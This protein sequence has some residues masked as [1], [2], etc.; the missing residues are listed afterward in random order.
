MPSSAPGILES[1]D[2]ASLRGEIEL[3]EELGPRLTGT[4][5]HER[6]ISHVADQLG[7]ARLE[8]REDVHSFTRWELARHPGSLELQVEGQLLEV[9]SAFPYSGTTGAAGV[10]GPLRL[11]HGPLP[12]WRAARGAIAVVAIR[13]RHLPVRGVINT[14][15]ESD[16]WG[17]LANPLVPALLAGLGLQRARRAGVTAV[18]FVWQGMSADNARG[19]YLPF[20]LPYQNIPAVF[21]AGS[22]GQSVLRAAARRQQATLALDARLVPDARTRTIWAVAPGTRRPDETLLVV[23]HSDGTNSVEENGHIALLAL[24]R[25]L[26]ERPPERSIVFVLS[27]G[28]LRIPALTRQGQ[29]MTR[30]L[31]DHP[32][33]WAGGAR[34]KQAVAALAIEH[35]GALEYRDDATGSG[36]GPTGKLEPELLYAT[37]RELQQLVRSEWR[38]A[39]PG[40]TR[41]SAPSALIHFGEG[42]PAY[43]QRIP[44]ISLCTAPQ[45]LLAERQGNLVDIAALQRQVDSFRRLLRRLDVLPRR[46]LGT[47]ASSGGIAQARALGTVLRSFV[48]QALQTRPRAWG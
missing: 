26:Q 44:G 35:L 40:R 10:S 15:D 2:I 34:Q 22:A 41:V 24:A 6:L 8:V 13:Q 25:D 31:R 38:G 5:A 42:E 19:Q 45:Y 33:W 46:Q 32:Q 16:A 39:D 28:H 43:R 18:V 3:L 30:W 12:H 36:S 14:W 17:S 37:T 1:V 47:V 4:A 7:A 21:V 48:G 29:A 9:S 20:T 27:T 23:S 11:L